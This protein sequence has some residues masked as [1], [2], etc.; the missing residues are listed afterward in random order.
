MS[1]V[2]RARVLFF[3][4]V[5]PAVVHGEDAKP[6]PGTVAAVIETTLRTAS[7]HIR[8]F[9]LDGSATTWFASEQNPGKADH[10]TLLLDAP[11]SLKSITVTTGRP[12]GVDALDAGM[13]EVAAD[14]SNFEELSRF[15]AGMGRS[16]GS[17]RKVRAI[18][19]RPTTDLNHPV[20]IREIVVESE[21]PVALFKYPIEFTVVVDDAP[22]MKDWADKVAR[23]CERAYPMINEEL[24]ST[25]FKPRTTITM[26]LKNDYNGVAMAG[27][28]RI[29][30]SVKFFKAHPE[31][32][33]AMVHETVHCVQQYRSRNNPGWLVEG[34]ADYV[35]FFK[36]EPGKLKP[37]SP[38]RA[39]Y[40]GSYKV[41]AAF[42]AYLT[43]KHDKEI[44]RKL[45]Q[46]MRE[47]EYKEE[48][49]K[50]LTGKTLQDLDQE[51]RASLEK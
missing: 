40:N 5:M 38:M 36:Y 42:L 7:D 37:L 24:Q 13:L 20:A 29:T 47:G 46:V 49:F 50:A 39:R 43:E 8:Q 11:V 45:N 10:F 15:N 27:G 16:E 21:P 6:R 22:E 41:T 33:G 1:F 14:G 30:G 12:D 31:D 48:V 34:I 28:G 19:I 26:T 4:L 23:I 32:V 17:G 9:A 44:V 18:R 35:R 25:G 2:A 3:L 51:W